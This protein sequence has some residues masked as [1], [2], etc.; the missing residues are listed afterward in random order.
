MSC[1]LGEELLVVKSLFGILYLS[2][3]LRSMNF[4]TDKI[5]T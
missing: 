3:V 2:C 5:Y 4:D 1:Y